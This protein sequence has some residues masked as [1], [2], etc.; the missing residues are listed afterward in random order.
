[1]MR[2]LYPERVFSRDTIREVDR[3]AIE[4]YG[5]PGIVLMENASRGL[6]DHA[7]RLLGRS[8]PPGGANVLALAGAGNNGGDVLAAARHLHNAGVSVTL[9]LLSPEA[10]YRGDARTNLDICRAMGLDITEAADGPVAT[11][12]AL[13]RP[14]LILDGL[15]GTGLSSEVRE[16]A[17][18]V[19]RWINEGQGAPVLAVDLPSGMDCDTGQPLGVCVAAEETVTFAGLKRGFF[20]D[21]ADQFTG[22]IRLVP[23]GAPRELIEELGEPVLG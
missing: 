18:E 9:I 2:S 8:D 12:K 1:M 19:I 20:A 10:K 11:L 14:G 23:I 5:I 13:P 7:M 15:L 21:G 16:P 22:D 4:R 3:L 6:A 17:A